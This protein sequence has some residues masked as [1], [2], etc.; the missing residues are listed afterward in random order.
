MPRLHVVVA[1][2]TDFSELAAMGKLG[3]PWKQRQIGSGQPWWANGFGMMGDDCGRGRDDAGKAVGTLS[4]MFG[5]VGF[6]AP[7]L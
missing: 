6:Q 5:H 1:Q 3:V 4:A 2:L 7:M